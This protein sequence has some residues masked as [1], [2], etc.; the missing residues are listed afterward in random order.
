MSFLK[1]I[2]YS[3]KVW[4]YVVCKT[5]GDEELISLIAELEQ[6]Q[7]DPHPL[8]DVRLRNGLETLILRLLI[9][10]GDRISSGTDIDKQGAE[11]LTLLDYIRLN[12]ATVSLE[13]LSVSLEV[14]FSDT[15]LDLS[16]SAC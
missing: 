11:I 4:P 2:V 15:L 7:A 16:F 12:V 13:S 10:H 8:T 14:S 6:T 9:C 1:K 5:G 3:R